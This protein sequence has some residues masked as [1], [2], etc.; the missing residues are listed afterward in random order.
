MIKQKNENKSSRYPQKN[1]RTNKENNKEINCL[2]LFIYF[3]V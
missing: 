2:E 1:K 3:I